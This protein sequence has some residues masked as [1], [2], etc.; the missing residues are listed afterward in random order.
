MSQSASSTPPL[1]VVVVPLYNAAAYLEP[2]LRALQAQTFSAFEVVMVDDGSVD[3]T[4]QI[5][6]RFVHED[7]RF[8][9]IRTSNRGISL[10][11]NT[12][13]TH[14]TA[15]WIAVCDG[16]DLWLPEKLA[17]QAQFIQ[18]WK[19]VEPLVAVGTAGYFIN[20][21]GERYSDIDP[22]YQPW[23][24]GLPQPDESTEVLVINS[25]V[26]FRREVF[27]QAGRYRAEYKTSEDLD[28]W[29]RLREIGA[30]VNLPE[31]LTEYRMHGSNL[32]H[33]S[34]VPMVLAGRRCYANAVRRAQGQAEL[35]HQDYLDEL[36]HDKPAFDSYMRG[37]KYMSY[38]NMGKVNFHN[39]RL[40][41]ALR[42]LMMSALVAPERTAR[43]VLQ[44]RVMRRVLR[45]S[46]PPGP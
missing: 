42:G 21:S 16:D 2:T 8:H 25:S 10:S 41:P 39:G 7:A 46:P 31:R 9:L 15:P 4:A 19:A 33:Q 18:D 1:F 20:A 26:V 14:S 6:L 34:F 45:H 37:L 43:M 30:L 40:L 44:S 11:R 13:V 32:S 28:M 27:E 3:D 22:P 29:L 35:S 38:Y 36:R 17:V 24:A 23:P 12:A 5:A